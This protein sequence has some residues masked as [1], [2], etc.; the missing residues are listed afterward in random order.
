MMV[1]TVKRIA[2]LENAM[3]RATS[4]EITASEKEPISNRADEI[5]SILW[6]KIN[7]EMQNLRAWRRARGQGIQRHHQIRLASKYYPSR[8]VV[9]YFGNWE[10]R[11]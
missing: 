9:G 3:L 10:R 8:A 2:M 1:K 7:A 5:A 6:D 4:L 11:Y